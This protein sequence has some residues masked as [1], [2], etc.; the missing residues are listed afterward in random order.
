MPR[1]EE[2]RQRIREEQRTHILEAAKRVFA[3]KGPAATMDDIASE[4]SISHGLAYRYF[5]SKE[6]I[7]SLL[8]EQAFQS[9][10]MTFQQSVLMSMTPGE[11]LTWLVSGLIKS[12]RRPEF[13]LLD[14][15]RN[16]EVTP[17]E[18]R[19]QVHKRG[20][21]LYSVMRQLIVKGQ[22]TGEVAAGDPDQLVRAILACLDGLNRWDGSYSEQD[23]EHFPDAE[24]FLRM[25]KP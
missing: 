11:R 5:V 22:E 21:A 15:M 4:A 1:S 13:I 17:H 6:E 8:A 19:E 25:L 20:H 9:D 3:R 14:H 7:L 2:A 10:P 16:S 12:G 23:D 18:L 24:I